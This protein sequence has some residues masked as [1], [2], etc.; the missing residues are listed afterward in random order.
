[1]TA[2]DMIAAILCKAAGPEGCDCGGGKL[3][4]IFYMAADGLLASD[5][6]RLELATLLNPWWP[7]EM[8]PRDEAVLAANAG[9]PHPVVMKQLETGDWCICASGRIAKLG[10]THWL[11]LP[12]PPSESKTD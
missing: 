7:I 6:V 3:R 5:S 8:A 9:W 10:P 4:C 12:T 11:P 1:M 2:R